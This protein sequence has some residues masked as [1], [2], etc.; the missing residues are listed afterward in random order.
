MYSNMSYTDEEVILD[1][2]TLIKL[3]E[4]KTYSNHR[5]YKGILKRQET[6]KFLINLNSNIVRSKLTSLVVSNKENHKKRIGY[7]NAC[8]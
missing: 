2:E 6:L 4:D 1:R 7:S 3:A 5:P 8:D